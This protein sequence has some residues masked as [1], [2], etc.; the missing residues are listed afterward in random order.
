MRKN[1]GTRQSKCQKTDEGNI[2]SA[3]I[4]HGPSGT[5]RWIW[6]GVDKYRK[7]WRPPAEF[8]GRHI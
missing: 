5:A 4:H 1:A 2:G 8:T 7:Y 6:I 3:T